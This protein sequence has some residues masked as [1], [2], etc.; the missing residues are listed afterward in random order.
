[1]HDICRLVRRCDVRVRRWETNATAVAAYRR[2]PPG[3]RWQPAGDAD[4]TTLAYARLVLASPVRQVRLRRATSLPRGWA[5]R[6]PAVAVPN[7]H[8]AGGGRTPASHAAA[9]SSP[10]AA[11]QGCLPWCPWDISAPQC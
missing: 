9:W 10:H 6:R 3:P 2:Y 1:M 4:R 11:R 8:R 5:L 7:T